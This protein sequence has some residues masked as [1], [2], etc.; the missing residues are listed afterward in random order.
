M[1]IKEYESKPH[2]AHYWRN[3][4]HEIIY[5]S[6]TREGRLFNVIAMSLII[7][8]IVVVMLDSI[9]ALHARYGSF[10]LVLEWTF[11]IL[12]TIEYALRLY[13]IRKPLLYAI[14]FMGII[15]LLSILPTFIS[16]VFTGAQSLMVLRALRLLRVFRILKLNHFISEMRFLGTA[17]QSS[18]NK[19][20]IFLITVFM[21]VIVMGSVM[22][23][24][25]RG[26]N[27]YDNIPVSIYWAIVTITTVGYGDISPVT[28]MGKFI[29]SLIMIIGYSILAVP[30]GIITTEMTLAAKKTKEKG[31][32][33][34]GCGKDAH[35]HD[36]EYCKYCGHHL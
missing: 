10:F 35:D 7:L 5:E 31:E 12:F 20:T 33:C 11:T 18:L 29:A 25:E 26:E 28:P 19:I 9:S 15:D 13:S 24:V 17:M 4:L 22:Y 32:C 8:S 2:H 21:V 3:R 14:S 34:P 6:N 27:G 23:L 36:A 30:T 1:A 16:I